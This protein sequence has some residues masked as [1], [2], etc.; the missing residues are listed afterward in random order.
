VGLRYGNSSA[1]LRAELALEF[2]KLAKPDS[3]SSGDAC[4]TAR[5]PLLVIDGVLINEGLVE[6]NQNREEVSPIWTAV[7]RA[8]PEY[9][10]HLAKLQSLLCSS[11]PSNF[12]LQLPQ[13]AY[14]VARTCGRGRRVVLF[15][16]HENRLWCTLSALA[17]GG[18]Y[19]QRT[20][21]PSRAIADDLEAYALLQEKVR[22]S[23]KI[24][25]NAWLNRSAHYTGRDTNAEEA[26]LLIYIPRIPGNYDIP[27]HGATETKNA[28]FSQ[29]SPVFVRCSALSNLGIGR[30][31]SV[32]SPV[33]IEFHLGQPRWKA[34]AK[35]SS[36]VSERQSYENLKERP[37]SAEIVIV[38][39]K[40]DDFIIL[41]GLTSNIIFIY[42]DGCLV[43]AFRDVLHGH[44]CELVMRACSVHGISMRLGDPP[45]IREH[46]SWSEV[47]LVSATRILCPVRSIWVGRS[48]GD[49]REL[50][51]NGKS[52]SWLAERLREWTIEL[53]HETAEPIIHACNEHKDAT[54]IDIFG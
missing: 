14:T 24:A 21:V 36:W 9:T 4:D 53:M 29:T 41:E 7:K 23:V 25:L 6:K 3:K 32:L 50:W 45:H 12:L 35:Y 2:M 40:E 8:F 17:N 54:R 52:S 33:E 18:S 51:S 1:V 49:A 27:L 48:L 11:S 15:S 31:A 10:D 5:K 13:G 28:I 16:F 19:S 37:Q 20:A 30:G 47:F 44:V 42:A 34:D 46:G 39:R 26:L 38:Q 22:A 43:T